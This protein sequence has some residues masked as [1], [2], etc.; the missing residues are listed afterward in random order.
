MKSI[1]TVPV[2]LTVV[3]GKASMP[4]QQLLRMGRGAVIELDTTEN[5]EVQILANNQP[6]ANGEVVVQGE[7]I[8]VSV[9][10]KLKRRETRT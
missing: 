10:A 9:T 5:D 8:G 1:H 3:L 6:I 4:I 2:E 7:R